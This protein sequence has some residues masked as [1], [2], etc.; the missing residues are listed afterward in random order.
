MSRLLPDLRLAPRTLARHPTFALVA[1]VTLALGIG[2][3]T[4]V[5]TLVDGVMLSPLPFRDSDELVTLRHL[6]RGGA[7]QLPMSQGLYVLYREQAASLDEIALYGPAAP[8]LVTDGEAQRV[9]AQTVTPSFFGVLGVDAAIGRTFSEEEGAP[10][11][12]PVVILSDG[13]WRDTFG[14]DPSILGRTVDL[15]GTVR[16]IVGVMPPDFGH[17]NREARLWLPM[18]VNPTNAPLA[19]FGA[20]GVARL[21]EGASVESALTELTGLIGRLREIFPESGAPAFLEQ[22]ELRAVVTPLKESMVGDV[23]TTL[24][25]LLGTVGFVLLIACANVANLLLV[26]A[27][28]RQR[29]MAMRLAIGASRADVLRASM[30]ESFVLS[31]AGALLGVAVAILALRAAMGFLPS[32]LPRAAEIGVDLRVLAFTAGIS[33]A[34]ALFFGLVP[35]LRLRRAS[36]VGGLREGAAHGATSGRARHALRN[37]LVVVQMA[38][39]LVLLAGSGLM[40]R[41]FQA[42]RAVDPGFDS[43]RILT[44]G[45]NIPPGEIQGWAEVAGFYRQLGDALR[46]QA[47]VEA[48]G[49][50]QVVPLAGGGPFFTM[51]IE[52]HPRSDGELPVLASH[53]QVEPGYFE[54]IGI[55]LL[56]GRSPEPGDG[57]EGARSVVVS[58]SFARH[59][60]PDAS[61]LGRRVRMG[62]PNEEWF[63]IVGVVAD[64]KYESLEGDAEEMVYWPSTIGAAATPQAARGVQVVLK[65]RT[66]PLALLPILRREAEALNARIPLSNPR[67]MDDVFA[68]ATSRTSFTM[69]LLGAAS[70]IALLL[71]LVGIYG[72]VSYVVSQRTREIGVRMALGATA[73]SVRAMVVRHGLLLAGAGVVTGLIGAGALSSVMASLLYGVSP[74]DPPTYGAVAV[75]LVAV[76][77][78]ATWL[79]ATRTAAVDPA[80]AL[81][82]D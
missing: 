68:A 3:N 4:A 38:L 21:A 28:A 62:Q 70:G 2:A 29:E 63:Q 10:G 14:A 9:T 8:N 51:E 73:P 67:T 15:N 56:E 34:C 75:V 61:P 54:A 80:R 82:A 31:V 69:A 48:V 50:A 11:A 1:I 26:R 64:A 43:E 66:D 12:D 71:G 32:A 13:L 18:P 59:W 49:F 37:S 40:L 44:A 7:D 24:W 46:A 79:P 65:A 60:W 20:D 39:A 6:G 45:F 36:L 77:L 22:V 42:L 41:S 35:L 30:G 16:E 74:T 5:F 76:S 53:N 27:E 47:G 57:A 25:I 17:P 81:R 23:D 72:V 52:D 33:L 55:D 78:A 58:E 19:A